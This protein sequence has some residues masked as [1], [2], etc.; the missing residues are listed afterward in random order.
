[1]SWQ[2][3]TF[4]DFLDFFSRAEW[5]YNIHLQYAFIHFTFQLFSSHWDT[6]QKDRHP[7]VCW[8][9]IPPS[10]CLPVSCKHTQTHVTWLLVIKHSSSSTAD[11]QPGLS[12]HNILKRESQEFGAQI[13]INFRF[14]EINIRSKIY[15]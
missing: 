9:T 10:F 5:L 15:V 12:C 11:T 3:W 8:F 1:M 14:S 7:I 13:L 4:N 6:P 2:Y